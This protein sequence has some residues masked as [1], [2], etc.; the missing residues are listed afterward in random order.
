ME[1]TLLLVLLSRYTQL[2]IEENRGFYY[3]NEKRPNDQPD[4]FFADCFVVCSSWICGY[5]I[6]PYYQGIPMIQV[7]AKVYK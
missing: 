3:D 1:M 4:Y 2:V 6:A 7:P 5:E